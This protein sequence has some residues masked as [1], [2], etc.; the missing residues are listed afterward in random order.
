MLESGRRH[1]IAARGPAPLLR[2]PP[3]T[4]TAAARQCWANSKSTVINALLGAPILP[5]GVIPLTAVATFI[6][7]GQEP[8]VRVD[9]KDGR[10]A[11]QFMARRPQ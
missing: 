8:L 6:A 2:G 10:P 1:R 9:F 7:W 3:A 5:T 11:E 4:R